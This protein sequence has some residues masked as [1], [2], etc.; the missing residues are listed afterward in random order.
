VTTERLR[1]A[2]NVNAAKPLHGS[3]PKIQSGTIVPE[4]F[5]RGIGT[6]LRMKSQR[7]VLKQ[8]IG[9]CDSMLFH[10][11]PNLPYRGLSRETLVAGV[12]II[13]SLAKKGIT[14]RKAK[15]NA[16]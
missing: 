8:I 2:A 5:I 9:E 16:T 14:K 10:T 11:R 4:S 15:R 1:V 12:E 13:R 3:L 6:V 7:E